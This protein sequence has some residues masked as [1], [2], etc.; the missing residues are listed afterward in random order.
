MLP[1]QTAVTSRDHMRHFTAKFPRATFTLYHLLFNNHSM[2]FK[3]YGRY[4]LSRRSLLAQNRTC[5]WPVSQLGHHVPLSLVGR[6]FTTAPS[7]ACDLARF[8]ILIQFV[9][10]SAALFIIARWRHY[11]FRQSTAFCATSPRRRSSIARLAA[12]MQ[13]WAAPMSLARPVQRTSAISCACSTEARGHRRPIIR[14]IIPVM[15]VC[16]VDSQRLPPHRLA[17]TRRMRVVTGHT[18]AIF[19]PHQ[20]I[21]HSRCRHR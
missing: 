9:L 1:A 13:R 2:W 7:Q 17:T 14:G 16:S 3:F 20:N 12:P 15:G 10:F 4:W 6:Y 19:H 8:L 18:A 21:V 5:S 11:R